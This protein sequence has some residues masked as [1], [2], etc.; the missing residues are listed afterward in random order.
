MSWKIAVITVLSPIIPVVISIVYDLRKKNKDGDYGFL[1]INEEHL[2]IKTVLH[3]FFAILTLFLVSLSFFVFYKFNLILFL[4]LIFAIVF[5]IVC[6]T[7]YVDISGFSLLKAI[8][9]ADASIFGYAKKTLKLKIFTYP[10]TPLFI[11]CLALL[12]LCFMTGGMGSPFF[13]L[14]VFFASLWIYIIGKI[15]LTLLAFN[16]LTICSSFYVIIKQEDLVSTYTFINK[17]FLIKPKSTDPQLLTLLKITVFAYSLV[18]LAIILRKL[19]F[20]LFR[21]ILKITTRPFLQVRSVLSHLQQ[22]LPSLKYA[23]ADGLGSPIYIINRNGQESN[24]DTLALLPHCACLP[25][26]ESMKKGNSS[27]TGCNAD[28]QIGQMADLCTDSKRSITEVI[29]INHSHDMPK[30]IEEFASKYPSFK[31]LIAVC[32]VSNFAKYFPE[33]YEKH[34]DVEVVFTPLIS[35]YENCLSSFA[36]AL[37]KVSSAIIPRTTFRAGSLIAYLRK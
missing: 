17:Y 33:F 34:S 31:R 8:R 23:H 9:S 32:C 14:F 2:L 15:N 1:H 37:K 24:F 10:L 36:P 13:T 20:N 25:T 7:R 35:G 30:I 26:C 18:M 6:L 22:Q 5:E 29:I 11:E 16:L 12:Y 19:T 21:Y 27:C 4:I 28:C 3:R